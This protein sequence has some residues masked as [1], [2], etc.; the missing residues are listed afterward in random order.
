LVA[1]TSS[2]PRIELAAKVADS[3]I[4]YVSL[5]GVTGAASANF[6]EAAKRAQHVKER[7]GKPVVVG[8]GVNNGKDVAQLAGVADGVV[9]GSALVKAVESAQD[10]ASAITNVRT[11]VRDLASGLR[12]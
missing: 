4:Y 7:S 6:A 10:R 2:E 5:T 11:L 8:F 3:F 1:P 9:V 12:R